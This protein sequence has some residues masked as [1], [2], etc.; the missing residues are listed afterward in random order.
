MYLILGRYHGQSEEEIDSA[1]T[2]DDARYLAR[3]YRLAFGQG[4]TIRVRR[5]RPSTS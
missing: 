1:D 5:T 4:W 2:L 3:E